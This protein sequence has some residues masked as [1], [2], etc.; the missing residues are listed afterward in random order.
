MTPKQEAALH[1]YLQES[2]VPLIAQ[3]LVKKLGQALTFAA[4]ELSQPKKQWQQ[5][6]TDDIYSAELKC[7]YYFDHKGTAHLKYPEQF[8]RHIESTLKLK[9]NY[10]NE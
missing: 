9:N 10:E 3:V 8:A 6:T 7:D 1:E 5:L 2:I 4:E